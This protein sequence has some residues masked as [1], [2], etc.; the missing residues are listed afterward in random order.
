[1]HVKFIKATRMAKYYDSALDRFYGG[2]GA[3]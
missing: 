2:Q 3:S 1:M